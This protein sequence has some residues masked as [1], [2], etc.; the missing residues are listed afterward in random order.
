MPHTGTLPLFTQRLL[1]RRFTLQDAPA[2]FAGWAK[3][4]EATR[5]L[6]WGPH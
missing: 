4:E 5:W 1:L 3:D 2:M 6:R